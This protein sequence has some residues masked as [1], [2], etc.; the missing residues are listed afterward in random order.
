MQIVKKGI[1]KKV[2]KKSPSENFPFLLLRSK[3]PP[4]Y[5]SFQECLM[6]K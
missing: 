3:E 5:M 1:K 2:K 6:P 4:S